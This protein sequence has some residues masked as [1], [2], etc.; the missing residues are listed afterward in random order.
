MAD[1]KVLLIQ[2]SQYSRDNVLCK[3]KKIFVPGLLF[4]HLAA[5]TPEG[6]EVET[7]IEIIEDVPFDTDACN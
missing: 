6:W 1:R 7:V 3:Q 2:A 5:M 4:P